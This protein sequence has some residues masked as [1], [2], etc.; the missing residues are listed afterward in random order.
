MVEKTYELYGCDTEHIP[1]VLEMNPKV[2]NLSEAIMSG[3]GDP[4][5]EQLRKMA[6]NLAAA[7]ADYIV[8]VNNTAHAF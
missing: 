1:Q 4:C 8:C 6:K 5:A 3:H 2:P 7:S